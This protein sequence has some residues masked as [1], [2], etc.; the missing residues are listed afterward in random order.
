MPF[1]PRSVRNQV[2]Y[3]NFSFF[4]YVHLGF[5]FESIKELESAS[6]RKNMGLLT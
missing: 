6:G 5:T 2:A 4:R 3:P 1:Y